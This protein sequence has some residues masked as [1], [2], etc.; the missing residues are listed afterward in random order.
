[1]S[2][3]TVQSLNGSYDVSLGSA[4]DI[5]ELTTLKS[6]IL[7]DKF[8]DTASFVEPQNALTI[9]ASEEQKSLSTV[10]RLLIEI[11]SLGTTR[12]DK[13]IA[14]G[15]GI[16]QDVATLTA[17]LYMRGLEWIYYPTTLLAMVDSCIGGKSSINAGGIKNLVGNIYP[18]TAVIIDESFIQTLGERD[19]I[20][21]LFEALKI[22][23]CAGNDNFISM[24]EQMDTV[25]V[26][27]YGQVILQ[28]LSAKKWFIEK[29]EF[30]K[31]ERRLLNFG[32]TFGHALEVATKYSI[33][34]GIAVGLGMLCAVKFVGRT[35]E[36]TEHEVA[37][38][39]QC[40]S[41]VKRLYN[42][43]H[44]LPSL[45]LNLF[46]KTFKSDKKHS[47]SSYCLVLPRQDNGVEIV[48]LQKNLRSEEDIKETVC[49]VL[50][51]LSE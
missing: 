5:F 44:N 16:I 42:K 38:H 2:S 33:P 29:D 46:L 45:D 48:E 15:G 32:H 7:I 39:N 27:G 43:E 9:T 8:F 51:N 23:Y 22:S 50:E 31:D 24:C 10:E 26:A 36:L 3:I 14:V 41:L 18:P 13:L 19:R 37:L 21:G 6:P 30:D 20:S 1:M 12:D 35:R 11:K 34:H 17:S 25:D 49:S 47:S 28:S 40:T 4:Q